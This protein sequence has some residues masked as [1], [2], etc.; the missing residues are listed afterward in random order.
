MPYKRHPDRQGKNVDRGKVVYGTKTQKRR[1]GIDW[2][3]VRAAE[4][5]N[6]NYRN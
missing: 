5:T 4:E 3:S 1:R 6:E 2:A